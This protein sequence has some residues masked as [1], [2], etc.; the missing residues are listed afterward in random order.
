MQHDFLAD[1]VSRPL[2]VGDLKPGEWFIV[3]P[4]DG[5]DSGHGGFRGAGR[6]FERLE[7]RPALPGHHPD[8]RHNVRP[9][10]DE[11]RVAHFPDSM[12]VIRVLAPS[13]RIYN[14]DSPEY[15][16]GFDDG[17]SGRPRYGSSEKYQQGFL[18]G[19][20]IRRATGLRIEDGVPQR[21][22]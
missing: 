1:T 6:L 19:N 13:C 16:A 14:P 2:T 12:P 17:L 8:Y 9:V 21:Q 5:D 7:P 4:C 22:Q 3:F 20:T 11:F 15:T 10:G 18:C